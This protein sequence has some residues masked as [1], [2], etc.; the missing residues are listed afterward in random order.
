MATSPSPSPEV[1]ETIWLWKHPGEEWRVEFPLGNSAEYRREYGQEAVEFTAT[2]LDDPEAPASYPETV[3]WVHQEDPQGCA[4]AVLAMLTGNTYEQVKATVEGEDFHGHNGD[5]ATRGLTHIS[6]D[7]HLAACGF[8]HRRI[9][10]AWGLADD[11]PPKPFAAIHYAQ[12]VQPSGNQHFVVMDAEGRVYD[13]LREGTFTL[14]D[15]PEVQSV[16]GLMKEHRA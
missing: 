10:G 8:F 12:V 7:R 11:W 6:I 16:V 9:Y 3:R 14:A 5:W 13:P 2:L 4:L 1:P 15:W